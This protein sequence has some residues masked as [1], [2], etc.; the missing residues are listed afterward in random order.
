MD[1]VKNNIPT[2]NV[3]KLGNLLLTALEGYLR[4]G[5]PL[6]QFPAVMLWGPPGVG[7]SQA[8]R[9]VAE[10]LSRRTGKRV[11]VTDVR[12]LLFSP[13]D[14]R[15]I[16]TADAEKKLS[17]WLKP[18]IFAMDESPEVINLLFLDEISAAPPSVQAAAYQI[19]LDRTVGEH[20]LPDN[21]IVLAAGNR[22]TDKSVAH[23]MPKALANRLL[24]LEVEHSIDSWLRWAVAHDI[25]PY[26]TGFLAFRQDHLMCFDATNDDLAFATPRSWEQVSH[27]LRSVSE[28][29]TEMHPLIAGC[30][31][32]GMAQELRTWCRVYADLPSIKDIFEGKTVRLPRQTDALYALCA[33]M[34]AYAREHRND[35][36]AVVRSIHTADAMPLDFSAMLLR[37]YLYLEPDYKQ[38]L[39]KHPDFMHW[40][41]RKGTM[42]NGLL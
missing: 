14:L 12:L 25:H 20:K 27:L 35:V 10:E 31:G 3:Q 7:K 42:L 19:A 34:T 26:I 28:D 15:G 9:Q 33:S 1:M 38:K 39:M 8:I 36:A 29:L 5:T 16:P 6:R 32:T 22:V 2:L 4:Q 23:K 17:V 18:K 41:Q 30:V 24:H 21:C 40:L 13:I 37:N 11:P